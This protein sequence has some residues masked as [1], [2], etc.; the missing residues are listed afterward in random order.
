M[1]TT[2]MYLVCQVIRR[3]KML[4]DDKK[5]VAQNPYRRPYAGGVLEVSSI[6]RE[7]EE[8]D[9][10]LHEADLRSAVFNMPLYLW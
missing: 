1:D 4:L 10:M 7:K 2:G 5:N 6:L 3:G 9:K 8:R